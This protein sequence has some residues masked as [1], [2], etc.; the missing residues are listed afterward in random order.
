VSHNVK[1]EA[2]NGAK[3]EAMDKNRKQEINQSWLL[4][5]NSSDVLSARRLK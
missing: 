2:A 3:A 4:A 5:V 1:G